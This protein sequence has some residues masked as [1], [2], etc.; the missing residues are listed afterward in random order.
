LHHG[1]LDVES[2]L[3][4]GSTFILRIPVI[5]IADAASTAGVRSLVDVNAQSGEDFG[6]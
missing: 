1:Q 2:R 3:G 4:K 6:E 5:P